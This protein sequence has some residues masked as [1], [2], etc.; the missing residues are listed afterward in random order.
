MVD[1]LKKGNLT[2]LFAEL[3]NVHKTRINAC[4]RRKYLTNRDLQNLSDK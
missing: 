1:A 2:L 3:R 4:T